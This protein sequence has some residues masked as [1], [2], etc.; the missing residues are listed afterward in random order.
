M[1]KLLKRILWIVLI[2]LIVF[3][4]WFAWPRLPIIT[5][6][7]AKGM[8]SSVFLAGK[9]PEQV[10]AQDLSFF[11][12][13]LARCEID[14]AEKSVS[15][16]V[17]GLGKR[18]VV[19]REGL[20]SVIVLDK[21]EEEL[22]SDFFNIPDPGYIQDT[23]PWPLGDVMPESLPEGVDYEK[24]R[25]ILDEA[26]DDPGE[27][28]LKKTLGV[29]VVYDNELIGE[30][31]LEGYDAWSRFHGW[32]MTKS[33]TG[34]MAGA[35]VKEGRMDIK[36]STG[37]PEW[38]GDE[39]KNITIENILHMSS[40]LKWFENY[41]T[42][43]DATVM[44]M[45]SD[46]M[47]ASITGCE[48]EHEPG[49][50]WNYSSGDANLL[51]GLIR[52]AIGDEEEYLGYAYSRIFHRIGM[53]NTLVETDASGLFVA[54]SYS[55]GSTRD[56]ARFGMLFLNRGIFEG[57]TVLTP[58]WVD[59]MRSAA[60]ASNGTYGATFWLKEPNEE[61]ALVDVPDDIFF[62]DGFLGQR[63][64]I[65]P[66]KKLVVVRMGYSLSNFNLNDFLRDI[67]ATLPD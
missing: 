62:A 9:S 8:C 1:K 61:R 51:S 24:L 3:A 57:D 15:A 26:I 47:F 50:F 43:S 14:Y 37:I 27:E 32:S 11:P 6:F 65:I 35:L 58:E 31:Y 34:A 67:I 44:L 30:D 46:D 36:N 41:F 54:S 39:R 13:S 53:L 45:Q 5:A 52:S 21:A 42:I 10:A 56:W 64:Y 66:S 40:G 48:L 20:G 12:I 7:A 4:T 17:F 49:S 33:V 25:T 2:A 63:I 60:P 28:A 29:A 59:F 16:K 19:F 18:K 55:Y 23:V 22:K 38:S